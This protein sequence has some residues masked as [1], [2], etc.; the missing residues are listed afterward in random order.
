MAADGAVH[1]VNDMFALKVFAVHID[2][3]VKNIAGAATNPIFGIV[4]AGKLLAAHHRGEKSHGRESATV[5]IREVA[6]LLGTGRESSH[7]TVACSVRK[8]V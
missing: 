8:P 2:T 4:V 7:R 3:A 5:H 1:G 6:R